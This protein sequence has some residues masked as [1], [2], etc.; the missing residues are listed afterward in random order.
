MEKRL[1]ALLL[2][3]AKR[4]DALLEAALSR[5]PQSEIRFFFPLSPTRLKK[6]SAAAIFKN[7]PQP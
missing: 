4:I 5:L 7:M 1:A 2:G 3:N 6:T